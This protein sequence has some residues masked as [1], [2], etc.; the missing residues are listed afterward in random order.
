MQTECNL[1]QTK[2]FRKELHFYETE[3]DTN[4]RL[5]FVLRDIPQL[6]G[7][8]VFDCSKRGLGISANGT[9]Y[10]AWRKRSTRYWVKERKK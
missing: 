2:L 10:C 7:C 9:R 6:R 4:N 1:I 3:M 8:P 5:D